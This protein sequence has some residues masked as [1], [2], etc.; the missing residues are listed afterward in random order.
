MKPTGP[1]FRRALRQQAQVAALLAAGAA[2]AGWARVF[3]TNHDA[4]NASAISLSLALIVALSIL[5]G[6]ALPFGLARAGVDPANAGTSIQVAMDVLGVA[7]TCVTCHYVLDTLAQGV[8]A[9]GA[10]G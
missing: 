4:R 8:A 3:L 10:V 2:A 6:T 1:S 9:A 7:L 5:L